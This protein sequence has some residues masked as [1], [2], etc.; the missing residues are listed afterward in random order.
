MSNTLSPQMFLVVDDHDTVL[1]GTINILQEKYPD[2]TLVTAKTAA[3]VRQK[4]VELVEPSV[5]LLDLSIPEQEEDNAK[6]EVGLQL[7]RDIM[8]TYPE[9]NIVVHSSHIN[10]LI[11]IVH[12]IDNHQ[13]GFTTA[14][15][16]LSKE[17]IL[18][19][20]HLAL[21]GA[22]HTRD[23]ERM[24]AGREMRPEWYQVLEL[25]FAHG[26]Q[27]G[28]IAQEMNRA[29]RTIRV[30]WS[31]IYDVLEVYPENGRNLR[32]QTEMRARELGLID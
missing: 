2:T 1:S 7:L 30:Y 29:E 8:P 28:A 21:H 9:L 22:T 17:E 27:D 14:S 23:I 10:S 25:A 6:V 19:R 3:G 4:L 24:H 12:N 15:K 18:E 26:L 13:G 16:I 5:L 31:K 32:I 11:R 20:V